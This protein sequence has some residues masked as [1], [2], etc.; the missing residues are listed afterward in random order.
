MESVEATIHSHQPAVIHWKHLLVFH[1][2]M[3]LLVNPRWRFSNTPSGLFN[4]EN[5]SI[6]FVKDEDNLSLARTF[7]QGKNGQVFSAKDRINYTWFL[8]MKEL[9]DLETYEVYP[10]VAGVSMVDCPT[11]TTCSFFSIMPD[12]TAIQDSSRC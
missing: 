12:P 8:L 5:M 7:Y 1:K 3:A 4:C 10:E 6:R 11:S 9:W 2:L